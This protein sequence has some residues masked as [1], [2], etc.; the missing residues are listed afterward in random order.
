MN[1]GTRRHS[2]N[3]LI[4]GGFIFYPPTSKRIRKVF[5]AQ[6]SRHP[7]QRKKRVRS[8]GDRKSLARAMIMQYPQTQVISRTEQS[9]F[10]EIHNN[11]GE[12]AKDLIERALAATFE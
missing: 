9:T 1:G 12:S 8:C 11:Y 6:G 2:K 3:V 5:L 7:T 4:E 10:L